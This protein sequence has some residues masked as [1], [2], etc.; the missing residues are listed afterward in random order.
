V[1][2]DIG[3]TLSFLADVPLDARGKVPKLRKMPVLLMGDT[4]PGRP[5][6]SGWWRPMPCCPGRRSWKRGC[7]RS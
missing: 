5:A 3:E 1:G 4:V 7:A 2:T 6:N